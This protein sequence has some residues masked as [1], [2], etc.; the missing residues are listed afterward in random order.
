MEQVAPTLVGILDN[1][2]C[3]GFREPT[4]YDHFLVFQ[5]LVMGKEIFCCAD[6]VRIH[7]SKGVVFTNVAHWHPY[8]LI[9]LV[10][11]VGH[12]QHSDRLDLY[13]RT[14]LDRYIVVNNDVERIIC[15][16]YT[17]PSPRDRQKSRMPSSA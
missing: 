1:L 8:N 13:E 6:P 2:L 7:I 14:G 12:V 17:S 15:L 4:V 5:A 11:I 3:G 9:V 10:T 16:L